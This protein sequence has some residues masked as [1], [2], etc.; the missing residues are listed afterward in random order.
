M[1]ASCS[2]LAR[3]LRLRRLHPCSTDEDACV[4]DVDI[5]AEKD[6][7]ALLYSSGTSGLPK[8]VML[9]HHNLVAGLYQLA[10]SEADRHRRGRARHPPVLPPCTVFPSLNLVLSQGATLVIMRALRT[11]RRACELCKMHGVTRAFLAPPVVVSLA[12]HPMVDDYDLSE[13]RLIH[14]GARPLARP[15]AGVAPSGWAA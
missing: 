4:P 10:V 5:D 15:S 8:G 12:K 14:S 11:G 7:V 9:S 2:S 3:H 13:L 6:L 1:F